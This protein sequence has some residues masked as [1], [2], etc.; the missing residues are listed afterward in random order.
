MVRQTLVRLAT[1]SKQCLCTVPFSG[2]SSD[3]LQGT[4]KSFCFVCLSF[5]ELHFDRTVILQVFAVF[6]S[7][8]LMR[9]VTV[10]RV[11]PACVLSSPPTHELV[12]QRECS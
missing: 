4:A 6:C 9:A 3:V 11:K 5:I 12:H 7:D 1:Q 2:G 10:R 8:V